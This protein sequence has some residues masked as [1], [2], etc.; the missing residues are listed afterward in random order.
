MKIG[1]LQ[2][3]GIAVRGNYAKTS[4]IG[5]LA[6]SGGETVYS[7]NDISGKVMK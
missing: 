7:V 4:E 1:T 2:G 5:G 3:K 6:D